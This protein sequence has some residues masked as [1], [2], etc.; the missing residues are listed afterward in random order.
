MKSNGIGPPKSLDSY[1]LFP[2]RKVQVRIWIRTR[3][4]GRVQDGSVNRKWLR[5][6]WYDLNESIERALSFAKYF[7]VF[8]V[9]VPEN[10]TAG[11]LERAPQP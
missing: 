7:R 5:L 11:E 2:D 6:G 1:I 3:T 9:L 4:V 8:F 10:F